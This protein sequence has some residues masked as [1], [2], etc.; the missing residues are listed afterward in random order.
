MGTVYD[1]LVD[2]HVLGLAALIGGYLA[3]VARQ[4]GSV[5]L[6]PRRCWTRS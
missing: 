3:V 6:V 1:V 2:L 5:P 4:S